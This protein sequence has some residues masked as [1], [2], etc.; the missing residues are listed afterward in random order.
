MVEYRVL[1]G[2]GGAEGAVDWGGVT[3]RA[4]VGF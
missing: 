2:G 4:G 1:V 3:E